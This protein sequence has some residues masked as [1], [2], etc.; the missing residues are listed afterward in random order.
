MTALFWI[1][2]VVD[3]IIGLF[4]I[5]A[6]DFRNSFT[7]TDI[8]TWFSVVFIIGLAGGIILQLFFK[9]PVWAVVLAALPLL[10]LLVWFFIDEN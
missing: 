5:A 6:K 7:A 9:K 4:V 10:A 1:F 2:W 3:L 8:N